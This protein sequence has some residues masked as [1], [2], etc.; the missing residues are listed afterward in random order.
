MTVNVVSGGT[1]DAATS[2]ATYWPGARLVSSELVPF[3][4][5]ADMTIAPMPSRLFG[6]AAMAGS[7]FSNCAKVTPGS[8]RMNVGWPPFSPVTLDTI[9]TPPDC[10]APDT[11]IF[12]PV[13]AT[14]MTGSA[15]AV[16]VAADVV[17][18]C[19][20]AHGARAR[21]V[22]AA[23]A[24]TVVMLRFMTNP[25]RWCLMLSEQS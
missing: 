25:S 6:S 7:A 18:A 16:R 9:R 2:P 22:A 11:V 21:P 17:A 1:P 19:D 10:R 12:L 20:T 24:L 4:T 8:S 15:P 5:M 3:D 23:A 13:I 14:W